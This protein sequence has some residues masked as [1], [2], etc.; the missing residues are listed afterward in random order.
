MSQ[1]DPSPG[2]VSFHEIAT[3]RIEL[4]DSDPLIWRELEVP[5][6]V[7]LKVLHDIVQVAMGWFDY[8]LW[9]FS[10]DDRRYGLPT[11]ADWGTG[12]LYD[13]TKVRLRDILK[14]R[15]TRIDYLYDFGDNWEHRLIITRVRQGDPDTG[16]PRYL[17]GER[18]A[19]P[20][21]CGGIPGFYDMLAILADTD[22][23]DHAEIAEWLDEYDPNTIDEI[24][25]QYALSR[26]ANRRNA[27]AKR[28]KNKKD[29]GNS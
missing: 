16:Y 11:D 12:R 1:A 28:L 9:E 29:A 18:N 15:R 21:D 25:M 26:I 27:A 14:P 3:L 23:P 10:L 6:S 22:H 8:H 7:T 20:E 19:P 24:P 13:A 4:K 5:T 2:A 17:G